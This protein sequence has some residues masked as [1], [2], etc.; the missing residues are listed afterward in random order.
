MSERDLRCIAICGGVL[1]AL[2]SSMAGVDGLMH[3]TAGILVGFGVG[4]GADL[5]KIKRKLKVM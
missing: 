3:A 1:L 4:K 5:D 2:V